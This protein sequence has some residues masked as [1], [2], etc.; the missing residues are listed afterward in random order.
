DRA[1]VYAEGARD[2]APDAVQGAD[3]WHLVDNLADALEDLFRSKGAPLTAATTLIAQ[4]L[5]SEAGGAP[6]DE[7]YQGK[8][9]HPQPERWRDRIDAAAEAGVARRRANYEQVRALPAQ[10]ACAGH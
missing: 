5:P 2:G 4:V 8:R 9:R 1:G 10:G 6:T 7:V 3:R